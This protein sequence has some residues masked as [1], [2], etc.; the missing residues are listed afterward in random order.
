[1]R[2]VYR[3]IRPSFQH[4]KLR[5]GADAVHQR[6]ASPWCKTLFIE[7]AVLTLNVLAELSFPNGHNG[8]CDVLGW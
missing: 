4:R 7:E 6:T 3:Q 2:E 8:D 1:M 5:T